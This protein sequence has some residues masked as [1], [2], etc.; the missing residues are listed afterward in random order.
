MK[1]MFTKDIECPKCHGKKKF[2]AGP[3]SIGDYEWPC[4]NCH[5]EG[6]FTLNLWDRILLAIATKLIDAYWKYNE[7]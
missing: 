5:G 6:K 4:P 1:A 3:L 7:Y 2:W